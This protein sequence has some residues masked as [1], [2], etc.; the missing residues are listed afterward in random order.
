MKGEKKYILTIFIPCVLFLFF[1]TYVAISGGKETDEVQKCLECHGRRGIIKKFEN[2][3]YVEAYVDSQKFKASVHGSLKCSDCHKDFSIDSHPK[4]TFKSKQQYKIRTSLSC[5]RCHT[6]RQLKSKPVHESLLREEKKGKPFTCTGCH[7]SHYIMPTTPGRVMADEKKY[8]MS[9]HG[10]DISMQFR[11]GEVMSVKVD[12]SE[13]QG[14]VHKNH[15]CSDCHFGFSTERHPERNFRTKRDY[16]IV[17]S[18]TCRRCHFDKYTELQDNIHYNALKKGNL[19]APVCTDCHGGHSIQSGR[20]EKI[21]SARRCM[22]CHTEVFNTYL[23]SVHGKALIDKYNQDVPICVDCHTA[24]SIIDPRT[25]DFR[26]NVQNICINCHTNKE[27]MGRYGLSTD[28]VRTYLSDFH[29][30][31]PRFYRKQREIT[32]RHGRQ[33]AVCTDCHGIHNI[34]STI[35]ADAEDIIKSN[36]VKTCLECHPGATTEDIPNAWLYHYEPD[37]KKNPVIYTINLFFKIFVPLMIIG[38]MLQIFLHIWRYAV[39]R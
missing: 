8:C 14:S 16:E 18:E 20:A 37:F 7:G 4:R 39:N 32:G 35:Y 9:C 12:I 10:Q 11:S 26:E 21:L 19:D 5:R 17:L 6:D 29:G 36:L 25:F 27:I 13:L 15:T 31:T 3:E 38:L 34:V 23:S 22:E 24:H 33:I 28:I 30:V 1:F 2:N